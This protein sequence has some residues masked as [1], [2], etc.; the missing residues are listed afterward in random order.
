MLPIVIVAAPFL[1]SISPQKNQN[2]VAHNLNRKFSVKIEIST[3]YLEI[4]NM[5]TIFY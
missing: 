3:T 4:I 5:T 1:N 2:S